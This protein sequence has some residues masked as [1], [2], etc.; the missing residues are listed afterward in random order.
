VIHQLGGNP[1][2]ADIVAAAADEL[3]R[4]G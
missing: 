2:F 3:A 4:L 1:R